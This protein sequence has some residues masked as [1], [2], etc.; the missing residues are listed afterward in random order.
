METRIKDDDGTDDDDEPPEILT[1]H[2]LL[3]QFE[4][5]NIAGKCRK[6][7]LPYEK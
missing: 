4:H 7:A 3:Q 5:I 6:C 2:A 1:P